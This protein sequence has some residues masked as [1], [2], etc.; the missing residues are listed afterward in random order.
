MKNQVE[1]ALR[2]SVQA[3]K[4]RLSGRQVVKV[5]QTVRGGSILYLWQ[6]MFFRDQRGT[7]AVITRT[8]AMEPWLEEF[9]LLR[10]LT[11]H[12][13]EMNRFDAQLFMYPRRPGLDFTR[14][15]NDQFCRALIASSP[16][17]R[18]RRN[19]L[20]EQVADRTC[21]VNVRRGD[22]YSVPENRARFGLD[23]EH[24][25]AAALAMA[26]STGRPVDD[27]IVISDDVAWCTEHLRS[28]VRELRVLE[29]RNGMFDDL[30][31]LSLAHTLVLANSTFSYW[32]AFLAE[33]LNADTM[34]IAPPFHER[35]EKGEPI[36]LELAP[37]WTRTSPGEIRTDGAPGALGSG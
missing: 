11:I 37:H 34:V 18:A 10:A 36:G 15:Q 6:E 26:N 5:H 25:V 33:A 23:I 27:I 30:A 17:F 7:R 22:Y 32:G 1:S 19:V 4:R 3:M 21:V 2:C 8:P 9:P 13:Q 29:N 31:A 24:H 16:S 14:A 35:D 12:E 28:V 20:A